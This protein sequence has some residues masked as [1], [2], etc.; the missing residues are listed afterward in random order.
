MCLC[1][2]PGCVVCVCQVFV[3]C[4]AVHDVNLYNVRVYGA[5]LIAY[6][7]YAS[8][9]AVRVGVYIK[10]TSVNAICEI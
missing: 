2:Y 7:G 10:C 3:M 9:Y 6:S 4:I 1:V 5:P 8:I